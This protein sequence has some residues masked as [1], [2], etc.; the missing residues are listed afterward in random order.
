LPGAVIITLQ[1]LSLLHPGNRL[2]FVP[3]CIGYAALVVVAAARW[4]AGFTPAA[5]LLSGVSALCTF[6]VVSIVLEVS[7]N[8]VPFFDWWAFEIA[9]AIDV[10]VFSL[11]VAYRDR[12][13][14]REQA[15]IERELSAAT[16]AAT[17]DPLTGLLNRRGL[18]T[19]IESQ[20]RLVA[21]LLYLDIDGFKAV[22]DRG[23]HAAGDDTLRLVARIVHHAVREEDQCARMG[24]DE[25]LVVLLSVSDG[26][27]VVDVVTRIISAVDSLHPLGPG[28]DTRI[29]MSIGVGHLAGAASF[30]AALA[31]ADSD[32]YQRKSERQALTRTQQL[33]PHARCDITQRNMNSTV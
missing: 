22:N 6:F 30:H 18:E 7:G 33:D 27:N 1:S 26:Q 5:F 4:R 21:T 24:G 29:G 32:L 15:Q 31:E 12:F 3:A 8:S 11:G 14:K 25:F 2:I 16:F 10:L 9:V 23:G 19:W 28:D 17:H 20:R 13:A